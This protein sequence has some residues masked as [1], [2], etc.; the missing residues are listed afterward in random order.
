MTRVCD[1]GTPTTSEK[2]RVESA[3]PELR[4]AMPLCAMCA[5]SAHSKKS[6]GAWT[7][8]GH[9]AMTLA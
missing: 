2:E 1:P 9:K 4:L 3:P 5:L 8:V 7:R 6:R